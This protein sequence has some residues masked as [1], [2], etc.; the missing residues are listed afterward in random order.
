M[1]GPT[2]RGLVIA[3]PALVRIMDI[4]QEIVAI[5][6]INRHLNLQDHTHQVPEVDLQ[7]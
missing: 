7:E 2:Q 5:G 1:A 4:I 3:I 6:V